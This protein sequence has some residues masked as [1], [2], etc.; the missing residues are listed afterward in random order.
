LN[1]GGSVLTEQEVRNCIFRAMNS[2]FV[3]WIEGLANFKQFSDSLCLSEYQSNTKYDRGLILRYFTMKNASYEF[4][5]DVEPFITE[6]IRGVIEDEREFDKDNEG[7]LFKEIFSCIYSSIGEDAWRHYR[8]GKHKG[9]FSVYIYET[10][11]IGIAANIDI[12]EELS[13]DVLR[14]KIIKFKQQPE[15][16]NNTGPGANVKSKLLGRLEFARS[17]FAD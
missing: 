7:T 4:E 8:D 3:D 13:S 2:N 9:A 17:F 1:T 10:L 15:F 16:I 6:Y 11:A 5:H 12:V 14:G